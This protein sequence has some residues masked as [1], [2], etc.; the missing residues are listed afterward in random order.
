MERLLGAHG[1]PR[2][3]AEAPFEWLARVLAELQA[4]PASVVE[5]TTLF[6]RAKFSHHE[7]GPDL[8]DEAIDALVTVRDELR[9]AA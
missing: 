9:A 6:E 8:K 4:S 2:Q 1:L 5:L 7:I 3:P